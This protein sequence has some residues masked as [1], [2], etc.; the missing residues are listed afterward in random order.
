MRPRTII[1][2]F[3]TA[4][5]PERYRLPY[6]IA[7]H[8]LLGRAE[9]ELFI[10]DRLPAGRGTAIDVGAHQGFYA[11]RMSRIFKRV[12]AF[13]PNAAVTRR[14]QRFRPRNLRVVNVALGETRSRRPLYIPIVEGRELD[15][16]ASFDRGNL[17]GSTGF[18]TLDVDVVPL[19]DFDLDEV[20]LIKIDVEG[21]EVEVLG[22]AKRTIERWRPVLLVE[23][24]EGNRS[25]VARLF[26][27]LGTPA[28]HGLPES[29]VRSMAG[30][31]NTGARRRTS[32]SS[33]RCETAGG[34]DRSSDR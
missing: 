23:V 16:W 32:S 34:S 12:Y 10:L 20:S 18:R 25:R 6:E 14:L 33:P 1:R 26:A 9:E 31:R 30:S 24:K 5:V 15:G 13:E 8:R 22:G 3:V 19:D 4:L 11:Y 2:R 28:T 17:P 27:D 21:H 29:F 7:L